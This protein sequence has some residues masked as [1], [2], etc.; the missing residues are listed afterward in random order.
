MAPLENLWFLP[1]L[2][3]AETHYR[4]PF[5]V[6]LLRKSEPEIIADA[7]HR[8]EPGSDLPLLII[9]KDAH[10]FPCVL[11]Q[12]KTEIRQEG[13]LLRKEQHLA[14]AKELRQK[15]H[16][17]TIPLDV[18]EWNGWIDVDVALSIIVRGSSKEYHNDNHR[19]SSRKPLRIF[20]ASH[21]LPRFSDFYLGDP[22]VHSTYTEDQVEFGSPMSETRDLA[23]A[24]GLSFFCVTDHSYDLDDRLDSYLDNDV[25]VPKWILFQSEVDSLNLTSSD[26]VVVRGEEVSCRNA[27]GRNVH[28]LLFGQ[29]DFVRG[30]G[31]SAERWMQATSE[32]SISE[33]LVLRSESG[34]AYAA[35][36]ME[37]V[38]F[39]QR[40]LLN[41]GE[42]S[43]ED[44]ALEGLSGFQIV[45]GK[46][47]RGFTRGLRS[48]TEHL[49]HGRKLYALAGNDAHGN[50]NRFRQIGIPFLTMREATTHIFG[51]MRTGVFVNGEFDEQ[52]LLR[53]LKEGQAI[54]TDGPIAHFSP[55]QTS[56]AGGH[57]PSAIKSWHLIIDVLSS[58]EFGKIDSV[59]IIVGK[60]GGAR[61]KVAYQYEGVGNFTYQTEVTVDPLNVDY[62]RAEVSTLN[63]DTFDG[64]AHFCMTNPLWMRDQPPPE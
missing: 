44:L 37:P 47:D 8:I 30:S 45:N 56:F 61:E 33:V 49:L 41:R 2:L 52:S 17:F 60:V 58:P 42:W 57:D 6:S 28:L 40:L 59:R 54:L 16:S 23:R 10:L 12:V 3:Y 31:D 50:F 5:F 34:V 25:D 36:A 55:S 32:Y 39:L 15:F 22:H 53:A 20:L 11:V 4:F 19:L 46:F 9:V 35:H 7:P 14:H 29:R 24:M 48:W 1:I 51:K 21:P 62:A 38:P 63:E 13:K 43:H 64:E 27:H 26:F 18:M